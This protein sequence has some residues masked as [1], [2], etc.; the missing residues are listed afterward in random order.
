[1]NIMVNGDMS[2]VKNLLSLG[3]LANFIAKIPTL[4]NQ[5]PHQNLSNYLDSNNL[6]FY[7]FIFGM[8]ILT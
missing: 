3:T 8:L 1:M 6:I 7:V 2:L 5:P 4:F